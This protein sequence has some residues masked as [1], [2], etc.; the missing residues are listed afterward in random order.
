MTGVTCRLISMIP[1]DLPLNRVLQRHREH[2][3]RCLADEARSSGVSRELSHLGTE[4][5]A[6]PEALTPTVMTRLGPQDGAD[7]RRPLVRRLVVRYSAAGL[8]AVATVTA[9]M[10]RIFFRKSR[11]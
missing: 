10:A 3:L 1:P 4:T 9:L 2:C 7:P 11:R 5:L 8:A 6:A